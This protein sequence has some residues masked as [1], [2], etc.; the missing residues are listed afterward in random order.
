MHDPLLGGYMAVP[1]PGGR[2]IA[3][4]DGRTVAAVEEKTI[5]HVDF[6][7]A[8]DEDRG[9]L[10]GPPRSAGAGNFPKGSQQR[11]RSAPLRFVGGDYGI[12]VEGP[13][14][15]VDLEAYRACA[16]LITQDTAGKDR[17]GGARR[18]KGRPDRRHRRTPSRALQH[19]GTG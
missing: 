13:H 10:K 12:R 17:E 5:V 9:L 15:G 4:D 18:G 2:A 14:R 3:V 1:G 7:R 6:S 19:L 16:C 8:V 11:R